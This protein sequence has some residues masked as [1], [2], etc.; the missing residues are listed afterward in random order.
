MHTFCQVV[1]VLENI[2][3]IDILLQVQVVIRIVCC[4]GAMQTQ[5]WV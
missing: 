4:T 3:Y 1:N 2:D 5:A